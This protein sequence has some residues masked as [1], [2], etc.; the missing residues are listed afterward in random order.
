MLD[1]RF[2]FSLRI[3][4]RRALRKGTITEDD[5]RMV[6][7]VVRTSG[8]LLEVAQQ[9]VLEEAYCRRLVP[10]A[11]EVPREIDCEKLMELLVQLLP[12]ILALFGL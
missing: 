9:E 5:Y 10:S 8:E 11:T 6:R 3:A 12:V 7:T 1:A 2:G 4:A